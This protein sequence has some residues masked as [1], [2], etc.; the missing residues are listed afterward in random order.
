MTA[1]TE[2]AEKSLLISHSVAWSDWTRALNIFVGRGKRYKVEEVRKG[3]GIC[4]TMI[5]GWL[6]GEG[7]DNW[8]NPGAGHILSMIAFLGPEF[9][10]ELIGRCE[11]GAHWLPEAETTPPGHL[12][13]DLAEANAEVARRAADGTLCDQDRKEL[14]PHGRKLMVV[15]AQLAGLA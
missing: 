1:D 14:R 9:T 3:T 6:T 4:A 8:R 7:D 13:A 2:S 5:Y 15:G 12:A 10:S 11:Q